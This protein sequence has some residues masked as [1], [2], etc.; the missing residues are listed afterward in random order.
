MDLQ[1]TDKKAFVSGSTAGIGL[2]I[3]LE[4]C[5]EGASVIINGRTK[6]RVNLAI[7]QI[8]KEVPDAAVKG[9]EADFSSAKSV[10]KLLENLSGVDILINNVGIFEPKSFVDIPDKDWKKMWEVNV[11]SGVRL[12]RHCLPGML[13][14]N[15]GRIIFISSESGVQIP[16]EMIHYGVT[17][18]AQIGLSNGLARETKG[19]NVTVN[20]VLPGST[21]SEG[22]ANFIT[23]LAT[24]QGQTVQ[25]VSDNFFKEVRPSCLIQRFA[26]TQEVANMVT[27]L[28]SPKAAATNGATLRVDGG[29]VS[30]IL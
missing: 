19:T 12:S 29:T 1:L 3:A 26:T 4:L 27:Y 21:W 15:W 11:L 17:K 30:T 5:R 20:C 2:A 8:R 16:Q 28:C 13:K 14:R 10:E 7:K 23:D 18:T 9:L 24:Q 22:A 6:D 25:E